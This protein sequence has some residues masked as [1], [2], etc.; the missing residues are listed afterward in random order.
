MD[1]GITPL[2]R[3]LDHRR[4]AHVSHV[5]LH[6][7]RGETLRGLRRRAHETAHACAARRQLT[8]DVATDESRGPGDEHE[9]PLQA[10]L[11]FRLLGD[12]RARMGC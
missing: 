2:H 6:G 4:V 7:Q 8:T 5:Q 3:T 9:P 10:S 1:D 11:E 12:R